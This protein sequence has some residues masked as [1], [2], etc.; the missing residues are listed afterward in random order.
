VAAHTLAVTGGGRF[1]SLLD[2]PEWAA[3]GARECRNER[4]WPVLVGDP[5]RAEG[6]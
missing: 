1:V 3:P 2:P 6:R 4:T 5:E